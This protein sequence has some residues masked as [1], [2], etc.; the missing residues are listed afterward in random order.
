VYPEE[1]SVVAGSNVTVDV[2]MYSDY[3]PLNGTLPTGSVS[4]TLG[5]KTLTA[6]F[7]SWGTTGSAIQE[8]VVTFTKVPAGILPL[9][10][11]YAGDA[12][13][14]GTSS[15]YGTVKALA[16]K[17]APTVT[18]TATTLSYLPNQTVK[19]TGTV[20]GPTGGPV[21]TGLLYFSWQD[22]NSYYDYYIQPTA[23]NA[24][25]WT[26]T[27]PANE[28]EN[29]SNLFVAT[30]NG[31]ANYSAQSSTPLTIKLNGSDFSL[32]TTTQAVPVGIG[33]SATGSVTV[34]PINGYSGTVSITCSAP[35]GITCTAATAA[36]TVGSGVV[37]AITVK[38]AST[39]VAGTYPAVV[40][41]TGAGH[42]H[43]AEILVAVH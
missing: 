4:V 24:A 17:P 6:P 29:G 12:N 9:T 23:S 37:D 16:S 10:A 32:T 36:P 8:A 33:K 20:T 43:T 26:L 11:T 14:L 15:L 1:T 38:A 13:W 25:A 2:E 7:V 41:A 31:D 30:Y 34:T 18:L 42:V 40:T 19:M 3:L 35:T 22:G 21:P 5:G 27:F 28:L 39:V